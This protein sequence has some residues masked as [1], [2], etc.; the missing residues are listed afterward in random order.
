MVSVAIAL[1]RL[2]VLIPNLSILYLV[3]ILALASTAGRGPAVCAA[4]LALLA[5]DFFFVEPLYTITIRDPAEWL[6]LVVFLLVAA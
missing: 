3:V 6:A 5:Y 2:R 4:L 1:I